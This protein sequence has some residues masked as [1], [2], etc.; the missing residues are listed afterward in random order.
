MKPIIGVI[1][2]WDESRESIW[3]LPGYLDAIRASGGVPIILPLKASAEDIMQLCQ[4]CSGFLFTGGHDI[5]PTLYG[6][7]STGKCG[8]PCHERDE[9]E[10]TI[11]NY[12]LEHD[13]PVLGI[14]RG[15]QLI[16]ALLG[17]TLYQDLPSQK[18]SDISHQM[19]PPYHLPCHKVNI[20]DGS[21]LMELL[22]QNELAVNSYHHQAI[23]A[24]APPLQ[25]IAISEDGLIEAVYMPGKRYIQAVQWHP[26]FNFSHEESSRKIVREFISKCYE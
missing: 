9:L 20:I 7:E 26:E 23:R 13:R 15:I 19:R 18:A 22:G 5:S 10:R 12:A 1:P 17:G 14:C 4:L 11:F 2:L 6:Q 16:N 3:M 8:A 21:P 24:L 25:A